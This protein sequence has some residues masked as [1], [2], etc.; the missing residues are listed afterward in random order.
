[1]SNETEINHAVSH[2]EDGLDV[3]RES[4]KPSRAVSLAITNAEQAILWLRHELEYGK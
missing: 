1:M 4:V 3:L 2:L